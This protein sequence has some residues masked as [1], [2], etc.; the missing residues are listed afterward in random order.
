MTTC[1]LMLQLVYYLGWSVTR[2][3]YGKPACSKGSEKVGVFGAEQRCRSR[4][5][6]CEELPTQMS[7][8][9]QCQYLDNVRRK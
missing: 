1:E 3:R 4:A 8:R 7:V 9:K 2:G 5:G 6:P